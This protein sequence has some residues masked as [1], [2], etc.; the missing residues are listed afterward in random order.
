MEEK[1]VFSN[2]N[3]PLIY[4]NINDISSFFDLSKNLS[5]PHRGYIIDFPRNGLIKGQNSAQFFNL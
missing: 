2:V 1:I 5:S 3:M 4:Q